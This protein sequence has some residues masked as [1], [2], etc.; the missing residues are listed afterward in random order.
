[1]S[2]TISQTGCA[3]LQIIDGTGA[4]DEFPLE[5]RGRQTETLIRC[6]YNSN[7][8]TKK[9]PFPSSSSVVLFAQMMFADQVYHTRLQID[10]E[11]PLFQVRIAFVPSV[12]AALPV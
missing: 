4:V 2:R 8:L 12:P 6:Y 10:S 9:T 5:L 7:P 3:V 11:Q 1:V